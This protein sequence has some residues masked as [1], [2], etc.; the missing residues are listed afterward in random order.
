[1]VQ[2]K[3]R[4]VGGNGDVEPEQYVDTICVFENWSKNDCVRETSSHL[5][6]GVRSLWHIIV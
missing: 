4:E 1:M 3:I 2:G 5:Q 6:V